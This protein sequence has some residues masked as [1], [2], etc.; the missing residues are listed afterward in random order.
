M[1]I[2]LLGLLM[3]LVGLIIALMIGNIVILILLRDI[4]WLRLF[5][6]QHDVETFKNISYLKD[7]ADPKRR[8]DI[9]RPKGKK[10][11]P[12]VVF[13]HGGYWNSGDKE[14]YVAFTGLYA[15]IGIALARNGIG[16]AV[17]NYRLVPTVTFEGQLGDVAASI[18]WIKDHIA[19][20]G[21]DAGRLYL[22]GHAAG[23]HIAALIAADDYKFKEAKEALKGCILISAIFDLEDMARKNDASFNEHVT[24]P[25]FGNDPM[26]LPH[27]SPMGRFRLG[28]PPLLLLVAEKDFPYLL[29]QDERARL[30][31]NE[32]NA[33]PRAFVL[34]GYSHMDPMMKFGLKHDETLPRVLAFIDKAYEAQVTH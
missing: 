34:P 13:V 14:Y 4:P 22:M 15:N 17:I 28:M 12:V 5:R 23:G 30:R 19:D 8:L 27:W 2:F 26:N 6:Q 33:A 1:T 10:G 9:Y 25:V 32:L 29:G 21:G 20:Y 31:L 7:A 11:F 18:S 3:S 24:Y 16:V